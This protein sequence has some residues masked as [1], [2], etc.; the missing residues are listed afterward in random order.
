M[1]FFALK[2]AK[3]VRN[4]HTNLMKHERVPHY[5]ELP[6]AITAGVNGTHRAIFNTI[7]G[8]GA[9]GAFTG[10]VAGLTVRAGT[11]TV[12]SFAKSLLFGKGH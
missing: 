9:V 6:S 4:I 10:T 3:I 12:L 11:K 1:L 8:I 2:Y 5:D 7:N